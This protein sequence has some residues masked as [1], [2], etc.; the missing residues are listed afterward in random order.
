MIFDW[1]ISTWKTRQLPTDLRTERQQDWLTALLRGVRYLYVAFVGWVADMR[2]ELRSDGTVWQLEKVLN[3]RHDRVL[4]RIYIEEGTRALSQWWKVGEGPDVQMWKEGEGP[5]LQF[6][7]TYEANG[8]FVVKVPWSVWSSQAAK[9][10]S[11][12]G[13]IDRYKAAGPTYIISLF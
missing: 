7:K 6:W 2:Y 10:G 12:V 8:A 1:N 5:L 13:T 11:L 3:D 9:P 4:R